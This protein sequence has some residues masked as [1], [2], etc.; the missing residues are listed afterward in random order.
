MARSMSTSRRAFLMLTGLAG[1]GAVAGYLF[2][3]PRRAGI[4]RRL[5]QPTITLV[6]G[7]LGNHETPYLH[8]L[9]ES[10]YPP[11]DPATRAEL[12]RTVAH[13]VRVRTEEDGLLRL[14]QSALD[15]VRAATEEAG[16]Q[17]PFHALP[18]EHRVAVLRSILPG[19]EEHLA[20]R[21]FLHRLR[22]QLD[23]FR[24]RE[25]RFVVEQIRNDLIKGIFSSPLGWS[26]VG[27]NNW[28]GIAGEPTAYSRPPPDPLQAPAMSP[29]GRDGKMVLNR[30]GA[31]GH[32]G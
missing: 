14:Y 32:G 5:F 17:Q 16:Y 9:V 22:S 1:V 19:P 12:H 27:Y 7:T 3:W 23:A 13:W 10:L 21:H 30:A 18:P 31:S 25:R 8:A 20:D 24:D 28:P 2:V 26:L 6:N 11:R 29:T 15:A 4:Y